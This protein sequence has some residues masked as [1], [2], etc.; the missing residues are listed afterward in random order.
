[1]PQSRIELH[2]DRDS[3]A[4]GDDM[5]SHAKVVTVREGTRLKTA[6]QSSLPDIRA[7]G[8]SWVAVVD[9]EVSAVWSVDHG[10]RLLVENR[11]LT[12]GPVDILFRYFLQ[13]D[14]AW[15]FD[16]LA[17]GAPARL[18]DLEAEYAAI[19]REKREAR[20]RAAAP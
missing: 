1:M 12:G 3:V 4:M 8:W 2:V 10:I 17:A 19:A 20:S 5:V 6:L 7:K 14:P 18:L 11:R 13:I 9:G 15:L 16:R